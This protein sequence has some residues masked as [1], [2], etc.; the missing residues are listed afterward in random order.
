MHEKEFHE[1]YREVAP[2]LRSYLR[3]LCSPGDAVDD[4]LQET[5]WR[6]LRSGFRGED[7]SHERRYLFRIATHLVSDQRSLTRRALRWLALQ[8][9]KPETVRPAD[10]A[11]LEVDRVLQRMQ[12][13]E[14]ALLWLAYAEGHTHREIAEILE[15]APASVRVL[16]F[17]ARQ[18]MRRLLGDENRRPQK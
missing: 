15:I 16:L 7:L 18:K 17:R 13:K 2:A 11:R 10:V 4:L 5:F 1:L 12:P 6:F 8:P 9:R 3:R 14:R